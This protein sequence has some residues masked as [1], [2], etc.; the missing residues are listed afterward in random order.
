MWRSEAALSVG[1]D[2][3]L[4]PTVETLDAGR[5]WRLGVHTCVLVLVASASW[6][7][8][9]R[10]APPGEV[11]VPDPAAVAAIAEYD[12]ATN[13]P[14]DLDR[15]VEWLSAQHG[16]TADE[17]VILGALEATHPGH[18]V[19]LRHVK[20]A[21]RRE[22]GAI[23]EIVLDREGSVVDAAA[24]R[25]EERRILSERATKFD[26]ARLD[27]WAAGGGEPRWVTFWLDE[28][29]YE[30]PARPG[31]DD[32]ISA[33]EID[34][35]LA[36]AAERRAEHVAPVIVAFLKDVGPIVGH[37]VRFD[38]DRAGRSTDQGVSYDRYSPVVY[39]RLTPEAFGRVVERD[40]V[41][42]AYVDVNTSYRPL[43]EVSRD[44]L[45]T[46]YVDRLYGLTGK[47][48]RVALI[49]QGPV[50]RR[51]VGSLLPK[52]TEGTIRPRGIVSEHA[53][54]MAGIIASQHATQRGVAPGVELWNSAGEFPRYNTDDLERF[55]AVY[56]ESAARW[57][58]NVINC[59]FG[60]EEDYS[61]A[62]ADTR[63]A[64]EIVGNLFRTVVAS[65]GNRAG[66]VAAP[67][68]GYNVITVG[69]Y[70][71]NGTRRWS[72]DSMWAGSSHVNPRSKHGDRQKPEVVAPSGAMHVVNLA[73]A[74]E[75]ANKG[76]A[77]SGAAAHVS[78]AVAVLMEAQPRLKVWP[79][80]VKA[81][82]LA[83]AF[84]DVE[85]T[86]LD[87][88]DG[89]GGIDG[90]RAH[91]VAKNRSPHGGWGGVL[92]GARL[93]GS[94]ELGRMYLRAGYKTRVAISWI[95][96]PWVYFWDKHLSVD[97]HEPSMD[98]DLKV[99]GVTHRGALT[100]SI[101]TRPLIGDARCWHVYA[102]DSYSAS[103][104]RNFE[105]V[106]FTPAQDGWYRFLVSRDH[107]LLGQRFGGP[108][109][110]L[111]WAWH[112]DIW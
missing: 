11:S 69:G 34:E 108:Q 12:D 42:W 104:D 28:P 6:S 19:T 56:M 37:D 50:S 62:P 97:W 70:L 14:T 46:G 5:P 102:N 64:D 48:T 31:A 72:D 100:R 99:E 82:L 35:F 84:H 111:A 65:A 10:P 91:R 103:F 3:G 73:G 39:L 8:A 95:N 25:R 68:D 32:E 112:Q 75:R 4:R 110:Y 47:G 21:D 59:S 77:T 90:F 57:G 89:V 85:G 38:P 86:R 92:Y 9:K 66:M 16:V 53:T 79:E 55:I 24:F 18:A 54:I 22:G 30:P 107:K 41:Q 43:L 109:R 61:Y 93:Q 81:I 76:V 17:L 101:C 71:Q 27:A 67:G 60:A 13:A 2:K 1:S 44:T 40:A 23:H 87:G 80:A 58:A 7:D 88:R 15:A 96:I 105:V 33:G 83:T 74:I 52:V 26:R 94:Q 98:L 51:A 45:G 78:G 36:W 49:E 106:E 63:K 20:V 29:P